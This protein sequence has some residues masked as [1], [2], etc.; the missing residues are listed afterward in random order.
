[1][2]GSDHSETFSDEAL[3]ALVDEATRL[4]VRYLR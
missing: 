4:V 3:E 2:G 1:V